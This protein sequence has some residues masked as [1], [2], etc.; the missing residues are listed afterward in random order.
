MER[1]PSVTSAI[2]TMTQTASPLINVDTY[3]G[4]GDG[5]TVS[6]ILSS[7]NSLSNFS[8]S[9]H[10]CGPGKDLSVHIGFENKAGVG[11]FLVIED[12]NQVLWSNLNEETPYILQLD[13]YHKV[14][15]KFG[16]DLPAE[17]LALLT[18][19]NGIVIGQV[20][21]GTLH[22]ILVQSLNK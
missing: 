9:V 18:A 16:V 5:M 12:Y 20:G 3:F 6:D 19:H 10:G 11:Y 14:L 2:F 15:D 7:A 17:L 13:P 1:F 8:E 21:M 22:N 4:K